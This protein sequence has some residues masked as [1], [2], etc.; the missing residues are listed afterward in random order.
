MGRMASVL[1]TTRDTFLD[2]LTGA[3]MKNQRTHMMEQKPNKSWPTSRH[4]RLNFISTSLQ[5]RRWAHI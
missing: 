2:S 5:P 1:A 4:E 3:E